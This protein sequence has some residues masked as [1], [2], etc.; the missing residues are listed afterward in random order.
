MGTSVPCT[1]G[2]LGSSTFMRGAVFS[3]HHSLEARLDSSQWRLP[4]GAC[5]HERAQRSGHV[6]SIGIAVGRSVRVN[7]RRAGR[8]IVANHVDVLGV[9]IGAGLAAAARVLEDAPQR[10]RSFAVR[11]WRLVPPRRVGRS[12]WRR[13]RRSRATHACMHP[14]SGRVVV[15][16]LVVGMVLVAATPPSTRGLPHLP[17]PW[18]GAWARPVWHRP[19]FRAPAEVPRWS[20]QS[21]I[22]L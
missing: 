4:G 11:R 20:P 3:F 17:R 21:N 1:K 9:S 15:L 13:N 12:D 14:S 6:P 18:R 10:R 16:V 2:V 7:M 22:E 5:Q 8:D 19:N